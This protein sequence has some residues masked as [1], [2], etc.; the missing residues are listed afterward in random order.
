M[1]AQPNIHL[2]QLH[3]AGVS[4]WLDTLSRELLESG[5]FS[6]LV[7]DYAVT[8]AT[9]NPTIFAKAITG[10]D[11]YDE[12]LRAAIGAGVDDTQELFFEIALEDVRRAAG[13]AAPDLRRDRRSR[14]LRLL[15]VHARPGRRHAGDNRPGARALAAAGPSE[16]DDQGPGHRGRRARDRGAHRRRRQRQ[17]DAAVLGRALRAGHRGLPERARA[18]RR[19]RA[20]RSTASPRSPRSSY[21]GS[22]RRP[23]PL[24]PP[25]SP[26]R[27]E[28]GDR[29][30]APRLRA[31][32]RALR[33]R[34]LGR[35]ARA[36][37]APAA[38]AVGQHRHQGSRLLRRALRRAADRARA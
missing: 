6:E 23:T 31:L 36:R 18:P 13:A 9:S 15:R 7:R 10:S 5:E 27:G 38:T 1:Q 12:Q 34:A 33:R 2:Q 32:P 37:G 29:K 11:R 4:I 19:A 20:S 30:R 8:G 35:P 16:R 26:L 3:D 22:T 17:R 25:D 21:R 24:L 14:R 28:V